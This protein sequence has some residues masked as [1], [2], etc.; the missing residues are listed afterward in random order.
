V[1]A[2][3]EFGNGAVVV[4][5]SG[6]ESQRP[7]YSIAVA[8]PAAGTGMLAV[9][10]LAPGALGLTVAGFSNTQVDLAAPGVDIVSARAGGG[11]ISMS[12]T[13]MATP[14]VAGAAV[15]WAQKLLEQSGR[16]EARTLTAHLVAR[17]N[18]EPLAA[19]ADESDVGTGLVQVP[20]I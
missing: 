15:L 19:G 11:L 7:Q 9:G 12:G 16:I 8:P 6:N 20:L 3:G 18:M 5:A 10:A 2:Q 4:A 17:S 1:Q 13:S 14:H